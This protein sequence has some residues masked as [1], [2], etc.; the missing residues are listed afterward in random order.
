MY[1]THHDYQIIVNKLVYQ[2]NKQDE[3][4]RENMTENV[5]VSISVSV[6]VSVSMSV[7]ENPTL[8]FIL[9]TDPV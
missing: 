1:V 5:S 8:P 9:L 3:Q 4:G 2:S 6:S 7:P